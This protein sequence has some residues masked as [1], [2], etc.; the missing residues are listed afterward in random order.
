MSS[1]PDTLRITVR[2]ELAAIADA[3]ERGSRFLRARG[4][5][6][7][8]TYVA[9]LALEELLSNLAKFGRTTG[10]VSVELTPSP[11][12]V[13]LVMEDDGPPFDPT[14]WPEP[15]LDLPL[16]SR[17]AGGL[18]LVLVRKLARLEYRRERGRNVVRVLVAPAVRSPD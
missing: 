17:R 3:I 15:D 9:E 5:D 12:A 10:D 6:D 7:R 16:E 11:E 1:E 8:V 4:T 13:V 14:A 18:G 2:A